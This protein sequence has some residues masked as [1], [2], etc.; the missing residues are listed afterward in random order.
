MNRTDPFF[1]FVAMM[2]YA[3][4]AAFAVGSGVLPTLPALGVTLTCTLLALLVYGWHK[5]GISA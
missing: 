4:A 5:T 1:V 2:F 3:L